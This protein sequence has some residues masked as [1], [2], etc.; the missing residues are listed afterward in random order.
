MHPH[1]HKKIALFVLRYVFSCLKL[2][3]CHLN[4]NCLTAVYNYKNLPLQNDMYMITG[5]YSVSSEDPFQAHAGGGAQHTSEVDD[6]HDIDL[7]PFV[8][9]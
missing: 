6:Q 3:L 1:N 5:R 2:C 9:N 4:K 8:D 7:E